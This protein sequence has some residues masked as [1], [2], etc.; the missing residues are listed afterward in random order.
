[1]GEAS[2]LK[3]STTRA[4]SLLSTAVLLCLL[5]VPIAVAGAGTGS[6]GPKATSAS[7][8]SKLKK[9]KQQVGQ[10]QQQVDTL[11]RQPG[12]QGPQGP[13]G[14]LTGPASGDL[15]GFFPNPTIA[16]GAV[17]GGPGGKVSDDTL[18]DDDLAPSAQ[19]NEAAAGG[20]LVGTYPSP[21]LALGSVGPGNIT[22]L[23]PT[24]HATHTV[25]QSISDGTVTTLAFDSERYDPAFM[26]NNVTNNSRITAPQTGIYAVTAQAQW[27][28]NTA[29]ARVLTLR[30]N[31]TTTIAREDALPSLA[32]HGQEVTTQVRL[33]IN[34]YVEV[35]VQ[36]TSGGALAARS[37]GEFTPE[38]SMT[39]LAPG[40]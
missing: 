15:T 23:L 33:L 17:S 19:F 9:L 31:G 20:S 6:D 25:D 29:G 13:P 38:F 12:P 4:R 37:L 7:L 35:T 1:L 21:F 5:V 27:G 30:K 18:T 39:W 10:L 28:T 16:D 14:S 34:D 40:P 22:S 3:Q 11:A 36:Q 24:V 8:K 2:R 26:H 32:A